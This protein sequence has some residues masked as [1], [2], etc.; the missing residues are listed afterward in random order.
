MNSN[1]NS[2]NSGSNQQSSAA[3]SVISQANWD[4]VADQRIIPWEYYANPRVIRPELDPEGRTP[5]FDFATYH[6]LMKELGVYWIPSIEWDVS[7]RTAQKHREYCRF[8]E[9]LWRDVH[10]GAGADTIRGWWQERGAER[11]ER[12]RVRREVEA[13]R[14][15]DER[16]ERERAAERRRQER[17][18]EDRQRVVERRRRWEEDQ[19]RR[20][21]EAREHEEKKARAEAE[22]RRKDD[23]E[24]RRL[25]EVVREMVTEMVSKRARSRSRSAE[26]SSKKATTHTATGTAGDRSGT[27]RSPTKAAKKS[28]DAQK[29]T[30]S[31]PSMGG[32][33]SVQS[34]ATAG[35]ENSPYTP[36]YDPP[37]TPGAGDLIIIDEREKDEMEESTTPAGSPPCT[38][39]TERSSQGV[40]VRSKLDEICD[41]IASI[42]QQK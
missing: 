30:T 8:N 38:Q 29:P 34:A 4:Q 36:V 33:Q 11:P 16:A 24:K 15:R 27:W 32:Q 14:A 37:V 19:N 40:S 12:E 17:D 18:R 1:N 28:T 31:T 41:A 9:W 39:P 5:P 10:S 25:R 21:R 35:T 20:E 42:I 6:K 26:R 2:N 7:R 3:A 23:E 22:R 13:V